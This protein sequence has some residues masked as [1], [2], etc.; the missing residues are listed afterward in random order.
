MTAMDRHAPREVIRDLVDELG[1]QSCAL[2]ATLQRLET[3][4]LFAELP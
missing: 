4:L 3:R 2:S 1:Q